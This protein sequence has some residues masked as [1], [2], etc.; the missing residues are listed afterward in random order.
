MRNRLIITFFLTVLAALSASAVEREYYCYSLEGERIPLTL[1][2]SV[3]CVKP[4]GGADLQEIV[5]SESALQ[6]GVQP[7]K[8]SDGFYSFQVKPGTSLDSLIPR[9]AQLPNVDLVNK[10]FFGRSGNPVYLSSRFLC[11]LNPTSGAAVEAMNKAHSVKVVKSLFKDPNLVI[12]QVT[13]ESDLDVLTLANLYVESGLASYAKAG[14]STRFQLSSEPNDPYW[15]YQWYLDNP[16]GQGHDIELDKAFDY[17]IPANDVIVAISDDGFAPHEDI[18][19]TRIIDCRNYYDTLENCLPEG[20]MA[21]GMSCLGIIAAGIDNNTGISGIAS[22]HVRIIAQK[23]LYWDGQYYFS[24][25]DE[26]MAMAVDDAVEAGAKVLSCSWGC[27]DVDYCQAYNLQ[28]AL[29]LANSAGVS[30]V[31]A[32][33]NWAVE[34]PEG[35]ILFPASMPEV[36]AVGASHSSDARW[37]YSEYG[38]ELDVVAPSGDIYFETGS[39]WTLDQMG[40]LGYNPT[41]VTCNPQNTNYMCTFGGTSASTAEVAGIIALLR[42]RRTDLTADQLKSVIRY[43]SDRVNYTGSFDDTARVNDYVGW[44]RVNADRALMAVARGDNDN[45]GYVNIADVVYLQNYIFE[46]GLPPQP[47]EGIGGAN[48]DGGVDVSDCVYLIAHIFGGGPLP[49]ICYH[50]TY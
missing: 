50:Y 13:K 20:S 39:I 1:N 31:A 3:I 45:S 5:A 37:Y 28:L 38:A 41:Y 24:A 35:W 21:H 10:C 14:T 42:A 8:R 29:Q 4:L 36:I 11:K 32:S 9:L 17:T 40:G 22:D 26:L 23:I 25:S 30:I 7:R 18:D 19:S 47:H 33:G 2:D 44:G 43:S 34:A 12:M 46:G 15:Q 48:C 16:L 27:P 6:T 49:K